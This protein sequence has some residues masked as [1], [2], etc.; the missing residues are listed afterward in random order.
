[1]QAKRTKILY[2]RGTVQALSKRFG[3]DQST[4]R[5]ALSFTTEGEMPDLIRATCLKEY[6][7][8]LMSRP[9]RLTNISSS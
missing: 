9:I 2:E 1:M 8:R 3:V 6:N 4:V 7:G 5:R